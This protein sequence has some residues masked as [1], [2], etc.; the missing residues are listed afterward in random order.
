MS[1][2]PSW[3]TRTLAYGSHRDDDDPG[4][5][6][7]DGYDGGDGGEY[8]DNHLLFAEGFICLSVNLPFM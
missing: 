8:A 1:S 6:G 4:D 2:V 7:D 5:D 3:V